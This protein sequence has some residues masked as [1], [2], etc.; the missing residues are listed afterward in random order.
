MNIYYDNIRGMIISTSDS[1]ASENPRLVYQG[2]TTLNIHIVTVNA[3]TNEQTQVDVSAVSAWAAAVDDNWD[4]LDDPMCRTLDADIDAT[5]AV[6]GIISV[7]LDTDTVPFLAAVSGQEVSRNCKFNLRGLDSSAKAI[8]DIRFNMDAYNVVDPNSG[9]PPDPVSNY[10]LK[11]EVDAFNAARYTKTETDALF[12]AFDL[13]L[14]SDPADV[15]VRGMLVTRTAAENL[16]FGYPC[17]INASGSMER[18]DGD[19]VSSMYAQA[20]AASSIAASAEG[21]FLLIGVAR[22]DSWPAFTVGDPIYLAADAPT[23]LALTQI[24]PTGSGTCR[25]ILG[26][27]WGAHEIHFHPDRYYEENP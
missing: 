15:T 12:D 13:E 18:A 24:A 19:S 9:V 2:E 4:A 7:P 21:P 5:S 25:Q 3:F 11:V 14:P 8:T 22:D 1:D 10:Y 6:S 23:G 17:R 26:E 20:M 27:A 16:E